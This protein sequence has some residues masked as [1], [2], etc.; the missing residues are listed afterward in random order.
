MNLDHK[1]KDIVN[2]DIA[3]YVS[4]VLDNFKHPELEK[5]ILKKEG[6]KIVSVGDTRWCTYQNH[7]VNFIRNLNPMRT[8][9]AEGQFKVK[10]EVKMLLFDDELEV[11]VRSCINFFD[12]VCVLINKCQSTHFS[13]ADASEEWL[14]LVVPEGHEEFEDVSNYRR[15]KALNIYVLFPN[16]LHPRYHGQKLNFKEMDDVKNFLI[17]NL[18]ASG[19]NEVEE[20]KNKKGFFKVL[21]TKNIESPVKF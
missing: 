16:H 18:D 7:F 2:L 19:L 9:I 17:E 11:R 12:P 4:T 15:K 21:F 14:Q 5:E 20:Y 13:I 6:V 8:I 1:G 3:K 10:Q